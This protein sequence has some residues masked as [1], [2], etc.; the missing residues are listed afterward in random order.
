[1]KTGHVL[2]ELY[3]QIIGEVRLAGSAFLFSFGAKV[4]LLVISVVNEVLESGQ[5]DAESYG[6]LWPEV[7]KVLSLKMPPIMVL[8]YGSC[9]DS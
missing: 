5:S 8:K 9:Y 3:G 1:M 7:R 6:I 2:Q 4:W